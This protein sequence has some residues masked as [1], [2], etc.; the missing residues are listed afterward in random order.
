MQYFFPFCLNS[1]N[2]VSS[3]YFRQR[4]IFWWCPRQRLPEL[5]G[6]HFDLSRSSDFESFFQISRWKNVRSNQK[7]TAKTQNSN[8]T[9]N[10]SEVWTTLVAFGRGITKIYSIRKH[11]KDWRSYACTKKF[12]LTAK[13][14]IHTRYTHACGV[15]V[16]FLEHGG[17]ALGIFKSPVCT[18]LRSNHGPL[19]ASRFLGMWHSSCY[20]MRHS[21][22][23][24]F[25][26]ICL[27]QLVFVICCHVSSF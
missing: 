12:S 25:G 23:T 14:A 20:C 11:I 26:V 6:R 22:L 1:H 2:F 5:F 7:N 15:W 18:Y 9:S 27:N 8:N 16:V 24:K 3:E 19:S 21:W 13:I 10:R 17:G 4:L